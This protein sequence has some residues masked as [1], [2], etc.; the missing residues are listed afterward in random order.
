[1]LPV[2]DTLR[3]ILSSPQINVDKRAVV[4]LSNGIIFGHKDKRNL[5]FCDLM[6]GFG[7]HYAK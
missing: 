1:M 2:G 4:N 6:D 7:I 3:K 5:T